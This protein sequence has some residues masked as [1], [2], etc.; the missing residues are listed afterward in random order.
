MLA[1]VKQFFNQVQGNEMQQTQLDNKLAAT[2]LLIEVSR[3][4]DDRSHAEQEAIFQLLKKHFELSDD[5]VRELITTANQTSDDATSLY[6]FTSTIKKNASREQRVKL[7]HALWVVAYADGEVDPQEE[8]TI[9]KVA[10]LLYVS[11]SDYIQ[12]KLQAE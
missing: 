3:A 8:A 9:R 6:Q 10:D 4:D 7:I 11:H 12:A 1:K 2:A 5:E